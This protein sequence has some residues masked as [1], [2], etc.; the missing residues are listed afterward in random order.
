MHSYEEENKKFLESTFY[1]QFDQ[2][3]TRDTN[4]L[5]AGLIDSLGFMKLI[6]FLENTFNLHIPPEEFDSDAFT[7]LAKISAYV[8]KMKE[9]AAYP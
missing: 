7:S 3:I 1:I 6:E 9:T 5:A 8:S 2:T 4:L